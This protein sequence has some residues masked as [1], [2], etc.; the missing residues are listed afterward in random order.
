MGNRRDQ[1]VPRDHVYQ[2]SKM[3]LDI[4]D[5]ISRIVARIIS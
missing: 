5:I 1:N 3:Y 2:D 4:T